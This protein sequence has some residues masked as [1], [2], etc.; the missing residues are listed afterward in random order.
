MPQNSSLMGEEGLTKP[1]HKRLYPHQKESRSISHAL[2]GKENTLIL[3]Q[4]RNSHLSPCRE[5]QSWTR[6]GAHQNQ[7]LHFTDKRNW[8]PRS[9]TGYWQS[10]NQCQNQDLWRHTA[11]TTASNDLSWCTLFPSCPHLVAEHFPGQ[12]Y[13]FFISLKG[14]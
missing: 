1:L 13:C 3:G 5:F 7:S 8:G 11:A 9:T 4:R 10:P 12:L 14:D 6:L 2:L